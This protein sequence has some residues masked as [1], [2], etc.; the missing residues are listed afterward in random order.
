MYLGTL[1]SLLPRLLA[2]SDDLPFRSLGLIIL[3]AAANV[4]LPDNG[5]AWH[6]LRS[7]DFSD[8]DL[9]RLSE[10]L[11]DLLRGMLD[12]SPDLRLTIN[13]VAQ[14]PI[15]ARLGDMLQES[16]RAGPTP[17]TGTGE[18]S[19]QVATIKGAI[20]AEEESFLYEVVQS[21]FRATFEARPPEEKEVAMDVD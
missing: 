13:D 14:H 20:L 1:S 3:E 6:K 7:N 5:P 11:V 2:C 10:P 18:K 8:V 21:V 19:A 9:S 4:V 15:V 12:K 17:I 16:L